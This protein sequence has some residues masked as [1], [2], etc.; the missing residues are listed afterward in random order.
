MGLMGIVLDLFRTLIWIFCQCAFW[1]IDLCYG[2]ILELVSLNLGGFGFIW[3]WWKAILL[4][5]GFFI[6]VRVCILYFKATY[7][8]ETFVKLNPQG[9]IMRLAAIAF[10]VL[11]L[12]VILEG[13]SS[14]SSGLTQNLG[15]LIGM[16]KATS[17]STLFLTAN[18]LPATGVVDINAKV[19]GVYTYFPD[20]FE[21]IFLLVVSCLGCVM[22]FFIGLQVSQRVYSMLIK[23]LISPYA[24][25][26]IIV[27]GDGTFDLWWKLFVADFLTCFFQ[28]LFIFLVFTAIGYVDALSPIAKLIFFLGGLFSIMNAPSGIA[29]L[30]GGD[31][32]NATAAQQMQ[33]LQMLGTGTNLA[34]NILS[35]ATAATGSVAGGII[36][37]GVYGAGRKLGAQS[38]SSAFTGGSS[39]STNPLYS[40]SNAGVSSSSSSAS[41]GYNNG[42]GVSSVGG[43]YGTS[44]DSSSSND[45]F[46]GSSGQSLTIPGTRANIMGAAM[47]KHSQVGR[48]ANRGFQKIYTTSA[49]R[50]FAPKANKQS[51]PHNTV[52]GNAARLKNV[53]RET[54]GGGSHV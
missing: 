46:G 35:G 16:E 17:P 3:D 36:A 34:G 23:I 44:S 10:I 32:G 9:L 19:N 26:G 4:F 51:I 49:R 5:L 20:T 27:E 33:S 6:I 47:E 48:L 22:F 53:L 29:S 50:T 24:V 37:S 40:S 45:N 38:L 11:M 52:I 28:I 12:P 25:S 21:I 2:F 42:G 30:L 8:E 14:I 43:S 1:L 13:L 54:K 15:T 7:D 18:G 39:S 31:V 41:N